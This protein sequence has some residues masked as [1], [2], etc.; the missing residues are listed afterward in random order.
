MAFLTVRPLPVCRGM[1][2]V[3]AIRN[4]PF[5]YDGICLKIFLYKRAQERL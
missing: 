2:R 3:V 4:T 1:M 5:Y